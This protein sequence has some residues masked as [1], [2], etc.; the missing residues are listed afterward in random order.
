MSFSARIFDR[1]NKYEMIS[2][3]TASSGVEKRNLNL[4]R[5]F[6]SLIFGKKF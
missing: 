3:M 4:S 1:L 6:R 2:F 5:M